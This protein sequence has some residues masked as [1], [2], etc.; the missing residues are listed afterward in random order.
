MRPPLLYPLLHLFR[1]VLKVQGVYGTG[2]GCLIFAGTAPARPAASATAFPAAAGIVC[3][4]FGCAG[5]LFVRTLGGHLP[6]QAC[7]VGISAGAAFGCTAAAGAATS[8]AAALAAHQ[9]GHG[10]LGKR[11]VF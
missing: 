7:V 8:A 2:S 3:L 5:F 6:P 10:K 1:C 4:G 11:H 9:V